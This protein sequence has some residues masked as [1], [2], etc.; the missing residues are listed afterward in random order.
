VTVTVQYMGPLQEAADVKSETITPESPSL[1]L[2]LKDICERY[3]P[4]FNEYIFDPEAVVRPSL[5]IHVNDVPVEHDMLPEL[6]D[7]D[8]VTLTPGGMVT[9]DTG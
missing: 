6:E 9:P 1:A 5:A 3:G 7:G 2:V 4:R 8:V